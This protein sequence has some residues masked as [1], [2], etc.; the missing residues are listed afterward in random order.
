MSKTGHSPAEA[1][2]ALQETKGV[3]AHAIALLSSG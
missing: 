1:K 3:V 2:L